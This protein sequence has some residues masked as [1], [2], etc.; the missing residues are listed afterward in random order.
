MVDINKKA[1]YVKFL[2]V[3]FLLLDTINGNETFYPNQKHFL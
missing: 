3:I 2:E 1:I